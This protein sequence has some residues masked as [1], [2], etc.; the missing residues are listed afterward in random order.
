MPAIIETEVF[1]ISELPD[2]AKER[3]R[4]W[5]RE[6]ALDHDWWSFCYD[7]FCAICEFL[8]VE[9]KTRPTKLMGGG[10][11]Q[12]PC[13]WFRGFWSQ[14][15]GASFEV[16]RYAYAKGSLAGIMAYAPKDGALHAIARRLA[17]VQRRNFFQ[18]YASVDQSGL[19]CH[20][21]TMR[22]DVRRDDAEMT[23]DAE[24]EIADALRDLARWLYHRLE[25]EYEYLTFD[26]VVDEAIVANE[27]TFTG[28]GERFG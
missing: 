25:A 23:A 2:A 10:T 13:I 21:M 18:L 27:Y 7:D 14:G 6:G 12:E 16:E 8:G 3:A 26:E 1:T 4:A 24:D 20:E 22:T 28:A 15:D 19:Y 11:R 9:L 5:Y 17:D